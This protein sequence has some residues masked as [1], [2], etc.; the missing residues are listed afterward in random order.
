MGVLCII[1]AR[2]GS[3]R[4]PGKVLKKL[5]GKSVLEHVIYRVSKSNLIDQIIVA[6]TTNKEDDKIVDECLK[7]GVNY[8]RGDE[9]NVLS[10]YYETAF[11][12][13]YETIIRIT[14]DCPLIDPKIIDNMIID[15]NNENEKYQLDYLSNSLKETFPRGF[16]VEIFTFNSLKEAYENAT[17]EYEKEHVTPYIYLNQDKFTIKNYYNSNKYQNYRL[18]LDTYEDY[19]VIKNIYDNIYKEDS[20]FFYEDIISYLNQYPE[21]ANINQHIKQKKL[22][23]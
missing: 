11:D 7:I 10:R 6:T 8:Y 9:N 16:D 4:L 14:S 18:T 15:F 12:K 2:L 5:S 21:I 13:G 3:T 22:G 19:L 1:Q 17:L 23:E 20:M